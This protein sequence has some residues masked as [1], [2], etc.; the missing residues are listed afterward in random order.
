MRFL[1]KNALSRSS[2]PERLR[3]LAQSPPAHDGPLDPE[4]PPE[5]ARCLASLIYIFTYPLLSTQESGA[6]GRVLDLPQNRDTLGEAH[7]PLT[8]RHSGSGLSG[9]GRVQS[10]PTQG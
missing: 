1:R 7:R 8:S 6:S 10:C 2:L 9:V 5:R 3:G 4:A